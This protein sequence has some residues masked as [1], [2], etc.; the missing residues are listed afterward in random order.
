MFLFSLFSSIS[1][2]QIIS[3]IAAFPTNTV[4]FLLYRLISPSASCS[5]CLLSIVS[6]FHPPPPL[7]ET[8]FTITSLPIIISFPTNKSKHPNSEFNKPDQGCGVDGFQAILSP[9][10][11]PAVIPLRLHPNVNNSILK[12]AI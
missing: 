3:L 1:L 5:L 6:Y 9:T 8:L 11:T 10:P 4:F 2:S 7:M 12:I